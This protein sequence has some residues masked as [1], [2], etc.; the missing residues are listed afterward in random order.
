MSHSLAARHGCGSV[1]GPPICSAFTNNDVPPGPYFSRYPENYRNFLNHASQIVA[2]HELSRHTLLLSLL[3]SL[4]N[5]GKNTEAAVCLG[6]LRFLLCNLHLRS[7]SS[8]YA[9]NES[10]C[11]LIHTKCSSPIAS[12]RRKGY[13]TA[14]PAVNCGDLPSWKESSCEYI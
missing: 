2:V 3:V 10:L 11:E 8:R 1:N 12:L 13:D 14:W 6:R 4:K 5:E 9:I 7:C